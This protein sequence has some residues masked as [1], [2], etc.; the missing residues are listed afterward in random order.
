MQGNKGLRDCMTEALCRGRISQLQCAGFSHV[1]ELCKQVAGQQPAL[2]RQRCR[3]TCSSVNKSGTRSR[4]Q[5]RGASLRDQTS[6]QARQHIA[7]TCRCHARIATIDQHRDATLAPDQGAATL[8]NH[9]AAVLPA[10]L[11]QRAGPVSL[12]DRA[13]R[14]EQPPR[15]TGMR[16]EYPVVP[17]QLAIRQQVECIGIQYQRQA[18][19][20]NPVEQFLRP[21]VA[22]ET[23]AT[24]H[25]RGALQQRIQVPAPK[26]RL[27][28][29]APAGPAATTARARVASPP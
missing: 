15:F 20:Q 13:T 29:S 11:L 8:E 25:D 19:A 3:I 7:H 5:I 4:L 24:G 9:R 12:H 23:R 16:R 22:T 10:E 27:S 28:T 18:T 14:A 2:A 1:P 21:G 17:V 6:N 26:P